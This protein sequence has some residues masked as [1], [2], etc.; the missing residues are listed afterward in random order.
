MA[1]APYDMAG[2]MA[3]CDYLSP[4]RY[5]APQVRRRRGW[6]GSE[7]GAIAPLPGAAGQPARPASAVLPGPCWICITWT[8]W[9]AGCC[10]SWRKWIGWQTDFQLEIA[11]QRNEIKFAPHLYRSVGQRQICRPL[12]IVTPAGIHRHE[13]AQHIARST[14]R[15]TEH[16]RHHGRARTSGAQRMMPRRS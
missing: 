15:T 16:L 3:D 9:T 2:Q 10:R 8:R 6:S 14:A 5:R 1:S 7:Q 13:L 12:C 11:A 4:L